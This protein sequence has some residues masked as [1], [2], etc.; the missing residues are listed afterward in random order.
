MPDT[1][2]R[3]AVLAAAISE[4]TG[5]PAKVD[6]VGRAS[7]GATRQT[8]FIDLSFGDTLSS[9][10]DAP[11]QRRAVA[12][13]NHS[14][15]ATL[16]VED[17]RRCLEVGAAAGMRVPRVIAS[18]PVGTDGVGPF[19]VTE[20]I[21]GETVPRRVLRAIEARPQSASTLT[22][23]L[24]TSLARLHVASSA[25]LERGEHFGS[26][27]NYPSGDA[28]LD[29][30]APLLDQLPQKSPALALGYKWLRAHKLDQAT[31]TL[32]HGDFRLG[33]F[34][35]DD[36][37]LAAILDWELA[38]LGDPMEDVAWLCLRSWR[39]GNDG[40]IIGG[41]GDLDTFSDAYTAAGGLWRPRSLHWW[42]VARTLW[43]GIM[44]GTQAAVFVAG[45]TDAIV[46]A[47][48]GRRVAELEFDLL[49]LIR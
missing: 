47:A 42:L 22:A 11:S 49:S 26:L 17:E 32:V 21:D 3:A 23:E 48:S 8:L 6:I 18:D 7:T 39:F 43:W 9:G 19:L 31:T 10:T 44:L 35:V 14:T 36:G 33:N 37:R 20:R 5:R 13:I 46:L 15:M 12:T 4:A 34:I 40:L 25:A 2:H 45:G 41:F 16:T 38:H 27:P 28:Y 29:H 1:D 30:L 24:A